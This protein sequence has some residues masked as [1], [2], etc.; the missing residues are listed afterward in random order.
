MNK[1]FNGKD[2]INRYIEFMNDELIKY[3]TKFFEHWS[4]LQDAMQKDFINF[5][6]SRTVRRYNYFIVM[7][8]ENWNDWKLY[9]A[10]DV[11]ELMHYSNVIITHY[12]GSQAELNEKLSAIQNNIFLSKPLKEK[13][14]HEQKA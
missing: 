11:F 13:K 12:F 5:F 3:N 14:E 8:N 10:D 7:F 2:M 6:G 1:K 4:D 9:L